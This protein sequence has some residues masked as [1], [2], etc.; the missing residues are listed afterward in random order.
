MYKNITFVNFRK[1]LVELSYSR[2]SFWYCRTKAIF[3]SA[4]S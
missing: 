1:P 2:K 4:R 3:L